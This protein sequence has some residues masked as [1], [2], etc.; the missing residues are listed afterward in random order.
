MKT[1]LQ[2]LIDEIHY[3]ISVGHAENR[4]ISRG[5][6]KDNEFTA[7][8]SRSVAFKGATADCLTFLLG[9]VNFSEADKQFSVTDKTNILK[10][11][12]KLYKEIGELDNV[13]D[14]TP[15]VS[16]GYY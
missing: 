11:A 14:S 4:L 9:A 3:P 2:A 5:L 10:H 6:K 13:L 7:E 12:N 15:S 16:F 8:V 1:I